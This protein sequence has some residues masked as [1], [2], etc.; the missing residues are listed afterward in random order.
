MVS[1]DLWPCPL[2]GTT[3]GFPCEPPQRGNMRHHRAHN[4][5]AFIDTEHRAAWQALP[6]LSIGQRLH[7]QSDTKNRRLRN[8]PHHDKKSQRSAGTL[9][10]YIVLSHILYFHYMASLL[11]VESCYSRFPSLSRDVNPIAQ[12]ASVKIDPVDSLS[13]SHQALKAIKQWFS[14]CS[15]RTKGITIPRELYECNP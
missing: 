7:S 1:M 8:A 3:S 10:V 2:H 5:K 11:Q 12:L 4:V 15:P 13:S 9:L 6:H 14:R